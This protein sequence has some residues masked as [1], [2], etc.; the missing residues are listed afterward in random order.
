MEPCKAAS[1]G[2]C[3]AG[4]RY[5]ESILFLRHRGG[6]CLPMDRVW[7]DAP[8]PALRLRSE[9]GV[10]TVEPNAAARAWAQA[11][12]LDLAALQALAAA[13]ASAGA[14]DA[15]RS[16]PLAAPGAAPLRV[17]RTALDDGELWWLQALDEGEQ[18]AEQA[19]RAADFLDRALVLAGVSVWRIDL[20][21]RR[22]HFNAVGSRVHGISKDPAGIPLEAVRDTVHPDDRDAVVRAA[23]RALASDEVVDLVARYRNVDGSWRT[24]LT[25]RVA[26]R[27]AE[28]R[29]S[30]LA[31]V[32]LN[33]SEQVAE[34]QRASA[35]WMRSATQA[36]SCSCTQTL[37]HCVNGIAP[38]AGSRPYSRHR[39]SSQ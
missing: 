27:D 19:Q 34:R 9:G 25:R 16:G 28:G 32:S 33:L 26:V 29:A 11:R 15:D 17:V 21:T 39:R 2:P 18:R 37:S 6:A 35:C 12:G 10:Q 5:T 31:G 30:G 7:L 38:W 24:L 36:R 20:A 8:M 4:H 14:H 13:A 23:D 1:G 3:R 22:V